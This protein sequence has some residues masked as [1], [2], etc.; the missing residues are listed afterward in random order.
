V[1][2]RDGRASF[3]ALGISLE[4]A[5]IT[6]RAAPGRTFTVEGS[7]RSGKGTVTLAG[8]ADLASVGH[9]TAS[10]TLKGKDFKVANTR[11]ADVQAAPDLEV[12]LDGSR[13]DVTGQIDVPFARLVTVDRLANMPVP[14]SAD[15]VV[16][17]RESDSLSA[18]PR[19]YSR[20]RVVIGDDVEVR[21]PQF[22]GRPKG[23]ILVIDEP[24][25][26]TRASGELKVDEGSY[27]AYGQDLKIERGR[28][29][30]GGGP[31]SN[32]GLDLRAS[33]TASDG[34]VAGLEITGTA[35]TPVL[36]IFSIPAMSENDALSYIMFGKSASETGGSSG[37]T[38]QAASSLGVSGTD[39][40]ARGVAG[41]FGI[42]DASVESKEGTMQEAS[43]FLGTYLSP[44]LYVSYG[45][46]LFE[47]SATLRVRY[48]LNKRWWVQTESGAT[49]GGLVQYTGER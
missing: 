10:F 15:V 9:P 26:E 18:G 4:D 19:V 32:P 31:I 12:R 17:G 29:V 11:E 8:S 48:R 5:G 2:L 1:L 39:M 27:R 44:K 49:R 33:R 7:L 14:A 45:I 34:T 23:S 6:L 47:S 43:V 30:F 25:E 22:R 20:V 3:P 35:E 21:V 28:L 42:Q 37:A 40:L 16:L 36:R 13:V 46:G 24:G 38:S 41:K